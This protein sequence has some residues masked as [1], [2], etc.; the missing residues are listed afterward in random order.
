[1]PDM[2]QWS[3][4]GERLFL[5]CEGEPSEQVRQALLH[6]QRAIVVRVQ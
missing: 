1:M 5:A 6:A 3:D 2:V 4:D